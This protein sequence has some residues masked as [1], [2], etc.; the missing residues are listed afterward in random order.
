MIFILKKCWANVVKTRVFN[1]KIFIKLHK[2]ITGYQLKK[3]VKNTSFYIFVRCQTIILPLL[4][5][6]QFEQLLD[7][8]CQNLLHYSTVL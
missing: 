1:F 7:Y 4:K 5:Y 6:A 2:H 8:L 3:P